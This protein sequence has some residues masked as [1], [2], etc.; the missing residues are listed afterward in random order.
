MKLAEINK[1]K[2]MQIICAVLDIR[3]EGALPALYNAVEI[4]NGEDTVVLEVMRHLG[5]NAVRC[6]SMH[7]TDGLVRGMEAVD[8]GAPISVPVGEKTLGRMLNVLGKAIDGKPEPDAERWSTSWSPR[9]T[10]G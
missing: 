5:E 1:G 3:F 4:Q 6:I 10:S 8:T 7:P 9:N 2:I